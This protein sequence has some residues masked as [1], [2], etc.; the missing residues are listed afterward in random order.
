MRSARQA[1]A[2]LLQEGFHMAGE[3]VLVLS[4]SKSVSSVPRFAL[5]AR[6]RC[7]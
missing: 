2:R 3:S 1:C 7:V 5:C 6:E 4:G